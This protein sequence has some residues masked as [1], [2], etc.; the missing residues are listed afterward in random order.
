MT[1]AEPGHRGSEVPGPEPKLDMSKIRP[2]GTPGGPGAR[3]GTRW[4]RRSLRES[5]LSP[6]GAKAVQPEA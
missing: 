1:G 6:V 5:K 3:P 2:R 4:E